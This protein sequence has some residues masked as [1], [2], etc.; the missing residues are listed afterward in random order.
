MAKEKNVF[1]P[2]NDESKATLRHMY[3]RSDLA[4]LRRAQVRNTYRLPARGQHTN[5]ATSGRKR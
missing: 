4:D 3:G 5:R 2:K 1:K